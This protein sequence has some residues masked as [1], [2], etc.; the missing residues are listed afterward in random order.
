MCFTLLSLFLN[1]Y[2]L[3]FN[4]YLRAVRIRINLLIFFIVTNKYFRILR[5]GF[6]VLFLRVTLT[7]LSFDLVIILR[8]SI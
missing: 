7:Y 6:K 2:F 3:A 5:S 8:T 1:W 4:L